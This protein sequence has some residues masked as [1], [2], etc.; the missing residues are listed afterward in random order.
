M[1]ALYSQTIRIWKDS[2]PA[3]WRTALGVG[4]FVVGYVVLLPVWYTVTSQLAPTG[5]PMSEN[6]LRARQTMQLLGSFVIAILALAL[7]LRALHGRGLRDLIGPM[8]LALHQFLRVAGYVGLLLVIVWILPMP[9]DLAPVRYM[10]FSTWLRLLP[11][12]FLAILVQVSAEELLFR[13]YLQ[14]RLASRFA[15]PAIWIG[16]PSLLFG[17][18]H[19]QTGL[20]N[21]G[22]W[23][24]LSATA[25]GLMAGDLTRRSGTLGPAVAVHLANNVMAILVLSFSDE[26][27]GLAFYHIPVSAGDPALV[28][29]M[30]VDLATTLVIWL[31]ARLALRR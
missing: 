3:L 5:A 22:I 13:G 30:P 20:G 2:P 9:E 12:G 16:L 11:L 10:P 29:L 24:I 31:T 8:P 14:S 1:N 25:F 19:F 27:G 7:V 15:S 4:L 21:N 18:L 6:G 26:L 23:F 28:P 17:M